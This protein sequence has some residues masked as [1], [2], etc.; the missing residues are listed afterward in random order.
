MPIKTSL[1]ILKQLL[2]ED[3]FR[4]RTDVGITIQAYL[5]DSEQ[6]VRDLI[7][8]V[9]QR[10]Y[11]LTV[12]LVKAYWDQETIKAVQKDW[13][14]PV[15]NDKAATDANFET[16]TLLLE[17]HEYLYSAIGSHNVR[18]RSCDRHSRNVNIPAAV[19]KCKSS[20]AWEI[21]WCFG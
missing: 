12:R 21:S 13:P 2:M 7:A 15:F 9:K 10:G 19:L 11:P 17:N 20:T 1:S 14:Q 5:R 4:D 18:S 6:D 8:W 3:E 16:I